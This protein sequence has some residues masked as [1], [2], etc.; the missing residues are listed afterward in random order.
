MLFGLKMSQDVFQ[1]SMD[2]I[3][4]RLP[5][6]IA[7]WD[8]ICIWGKTPKQHDDHLTLPMQRAN[9]DGLIFNGKKY[10]I[11]KTEVSFYGAVFTKDSIKPDPAEVQAIQDLPMLKN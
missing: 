7:I 10:N 4:G 6:I 9:K 1:M 5:G 11:R 8:D 2:Q 3:R